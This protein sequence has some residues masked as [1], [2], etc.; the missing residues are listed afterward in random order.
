MPR[1]ITDI[2]EAATLLQEATRVLIVGSSGAGKTT[3]AREVA[4]RLRLTHISMD[5]EFFW[6]PDCVARGR[7]EQREMIAEAVMNDRWVM[8]GS[9]PSS[10]DLRL[11]RTNIVLWMRVPRVVCIYSVYR[12]AIKTYGLTRD[13]MAAGCT[14]QLPDK[15]F[16]SYIWNF[17]RRHAP[18]LERN[19]DLYGPHVP[20]FQVKSRREADRL[21]DLMRSAH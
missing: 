5:K 8:D 1:Y 2:S 17:D 21:L 3:L 12:R 15:E 20:I 4:K 16:L 10:F 13:D 9:N 18:I 6:L 19:F 14:E 11:P 7:S